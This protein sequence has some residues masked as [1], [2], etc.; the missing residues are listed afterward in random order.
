[1]KV[2][3]SLNLSTLLLLFPITCVDGNTPIGGLGT[4]FEEGEEG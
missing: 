2:L 1:M 4:N 3:E